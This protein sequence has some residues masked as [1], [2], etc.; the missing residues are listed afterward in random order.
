MDGYTWAMGKYRSNV[1]A[2]I[3]NRKGMI[4]VCERK[5]HKGSWQFP[6]GGVD[7]GEGLKDALHR[8]VLEE[9]GLK[10]KHYKVVEQRG[11]YRYAYPSSV[12][13]KKKF[14]GQ[15]Q[16]Y[17]LCKMKKSSPDPDLGERN[18]EFRDWEW[19]DPE[20]FEEYWLPEFKLEVYRAVMRD[21]FGVELS[22]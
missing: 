16:T 22:K 9:V 15:D 20:D 18:P 2:L 17:F 14:E 6:Q 1:A 4:L 8:E 19:V 21:F 7:E 12:R 5:K 3:L 10:K 11:G 13:K